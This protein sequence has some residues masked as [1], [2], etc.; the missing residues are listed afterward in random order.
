MGESRG[1]TED[2]QLKDAYR[3]IYNGGTQFRRPEFFQKVLTSKEIKLKSKHANIAGLQIADLIAHPLKQEILIE[4]G[5]ISDTLDE[6]FGRR[7]CGIMKRKYNKHFY[8][9]RVDGYG[10]VFLK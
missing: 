2:T 10:K 7:I 6:V 1:R 9:G 3:C 4:K 5:R 8:T